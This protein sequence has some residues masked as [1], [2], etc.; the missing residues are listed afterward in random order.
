MK[1]LQTKLM[2]TSK[3]KLKAIA[4]V[5]A[6]IDDGKT[7]EEKARALKISRATLWRWSKK[8]NVRAELAKHVDSEF[9]W[10]ALS[11]KQTLVQ[12]AIAEDLK[13]IQLYLELTDDIGIEARVRRL[14]DAGV[15]PAVYA[16]LYRQITAAKNYPKS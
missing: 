6:Q 13:A 12:R 7:M 8:A 14:I 9:Q 16:D 4:A 15:T 10:L 11:V 2:D 5:L 1:Q 3:E